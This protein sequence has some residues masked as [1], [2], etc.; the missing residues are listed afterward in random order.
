M[1]TLVVG[2]NIDLNSAASQSEISL[3]GGDQPF[4]AG[5]SAVAVFNVTAIPGT[6]FQ[7][8]GREDSSSGFTTIAEVLTADG[9]GV[10]MFNVK[11]QQEIR[12]TV[13][14]TVVGRGSIHLL[15][16]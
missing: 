10:F 13:V 12:V 11:L 8:E 1:R 15:N 5:A 14:G 7:L 3:A 6:A 16:N 4:R 9:I 2:E